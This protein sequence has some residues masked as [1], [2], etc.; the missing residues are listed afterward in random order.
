MYL[1]Y[2]YGIST[3]ANF[4]SLLHCGSQIKLEAIHTKGKEQKGRKK[5]LSPKHRYASGQKTM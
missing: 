5:V 4:S 1:F 3:T 2:M